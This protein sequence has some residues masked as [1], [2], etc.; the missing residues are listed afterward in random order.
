MSEFRQSVREMRTSEKSDSHLHVLAK[1]IA[2]GLPLFTDASPDSKNEAIMTNKPV[3]LDDS[4]SYP[5]AWVCR[6]FQMH[7]NTL[8]RRLYMIGVKTST[9]GWMIPAQIVRRVTE[10]GAR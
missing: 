3:K 10:M 7:P 4:A 6:S 1:V 2:G 8:R 9:R 5:A